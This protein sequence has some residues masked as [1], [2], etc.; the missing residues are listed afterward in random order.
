MGKNKFHQQRPQGQNQHQR[1]QAPQTP[2]NAE[3][4]EKE[5]A[6][7]DTPA[8]VASNLANVAESYMPQ[9]AV[10]N[11]VL[12]TDALKLDIQQ[13]KE[14]DID[15]TALEI[16]ADTIENLFIIEKG[17][18]LSEAEMTKLKAEIA[19]W[20]AERNAAAKAIEESFKLIFGSTEGLVLSEAPGAARYRDLLAAECPTVLPAETST[21]KV[22][23]SNEAMLDAICNSI[24]AVVTN[25][26]AL[27][28]YSLL[29]GEEPTQG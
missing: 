11:Y 21:V 10:D 2:V 17:T 14:Q 25:A 3:P 8:P 24:A 9:E 19:A 15:P 20:E 27:E 18:S 4:I 6:V 7:I 23:S 1:Q 16:W 5:V 29:A 13:M 22:L 28:I 12:F 26:S